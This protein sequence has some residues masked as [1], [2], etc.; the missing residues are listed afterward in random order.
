MW[1]WKNP[2]ENITKKQAL[3]GVVVLIIVIVV[4]SNG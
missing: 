3:I 1:N 2:F 4:L